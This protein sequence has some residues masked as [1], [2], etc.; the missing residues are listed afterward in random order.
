MKKNV[1][2]YITKTE[3]EVLSSE[4]IAHTF[5]KENH[6]TLYHQGTTQPQL[7]L[8]D[9]FNKISL[10]HFA[11][12][13]K[14]TN[15][16]TQIKAGLTPIAE[17]ISNLPSPPSEITIHIPR[18][19][20]SKTN[21]IINFIRYHFPKAKVSTA[22]IPHGVVNFSLL[23]ISIRKKLKF[24]IRNALSRLDKNNPDISYYIPTGDLI[25][26]LDKITRTIYVLPGA[27]HPYPAEKIKYLP[28]F[29]QFIG[30][31]QKN[32]TPKS[33]ALIIGQPALKSG[34]LSKKNHDEI[35]SHIKEWLHENLI[36]EVLYSKHPRSGEHLDFYDP[37]YSI[38]EQNSAIERLIP[39]L[40][41]SHVISCYSAA[42]FTAKMMLGDEVRVISFGARLA[43]FKNK[44]E[45]IGIMQ[46]LNIEIL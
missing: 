28:S 23:K 19:S 16:Y 37:N 40:G 42:L 36:D 43:N 31:P 45:I 30:N 44:K 17:E 8:C 46:K 27:P 33:K 10:L 38:L 39:E 15:R 34:T 32:T 20:T 14:T 7:L 21:F 24:I 12:P 9:S 18:L 11:P 5:D 22:I 4:I 3:L 13:Q 41:I 1:S 26:G 2:I 6:R 25:G 29:N 35:N